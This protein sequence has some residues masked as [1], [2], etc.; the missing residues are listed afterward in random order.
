M[1]PTASVAGLSLA[2]SE[3][4]AIK[5]HQSYGMQWYPLQGSGLIANLFHH[6]AKPVP[7]IVG[8][9]ASEVRCRVNIPDTIIFE[10]NEPHAW[11]FTSGTGEMMR[12]LSQRLHNDTVYASFKRTAGDG[13]A[14]GLSRFM[15][16]LPSKSKARDICAVFMSEQSVG[17]SSPVTSGAPL[18]PLL[19]CVEGRCSCLNPH[20]PS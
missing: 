4:K 20:S 2:E 10:H 15:E 12:K 1:D 7:V 11:Y 8:T 14:S 5:F 17:V 19:P 13:T 18:F 6:L 3:A 16:S 9:D